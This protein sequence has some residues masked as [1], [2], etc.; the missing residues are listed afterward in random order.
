MR[1]S[2]WRLAVALIGSVGI[3]LASRS[4]GQVPLRQADPSQG[5]Q[6]SV[7]VNPPP[8]PARRLT[9]T[10]TLRQ[11]LKETQDR[12]QAYEADNLALRR[13]N[14]LSENTVRTL[15]ESLA[16]ANAER[17][18][19]RRQYGELKLRMEALGMASVGDNK[20]ALEER[21]LNAVRDLALVRDEKEK[22]AER[23]VALSET[24][25]L[26]MKS[27]TVADAKVRLEMEAQL[28]AS[29][30][31]VQAD[32]LGKTDKNQPE[33]PPATLTDAKV[34]STKEEFS[35]IIAN[36][37]SRDGVKIG[38]PFQVVRDNKFVARA[39]VVDVRERI[40]GAIVEEYSS[41]QEKVKVG[42]GLRVELQG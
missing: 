31:A 14:D 10:E 27:A 39:R 34:V 2:A 7:N 38:M 22:I 28:R 18:V 11:Q 23:L 37:G 15:D 13:R 33:E 35:L 6:P 3:V 5:G 21:L 26:Y 20:E 9:P 4:P 42:D 16:V 17:E 30:E 8:E 41:N 36:V 19:F 1:G 29:N 40:S 24:V 12:L 32:R 25:M